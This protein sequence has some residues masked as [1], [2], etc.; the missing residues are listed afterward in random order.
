MNTFI[1]NS[2]GLLREEYVQINI[3]DQV[4]WTLIY[5]SAVCSS[6]T[7]TGQSEAWS[8]LTRIIK[9]KV[10]HLLLWFSC[11]PVQGLRRCVDPALFFL[12]PEA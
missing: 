11:L 1:E 7:T 10:V 9:V 8:R 2:Y 6:L 5:V 4:F 12:V 3:L